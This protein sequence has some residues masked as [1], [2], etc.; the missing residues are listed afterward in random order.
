MV[1]LAAPSAGSVLAPVLDPAFLLLSVLLAGGYGWLLV[2]RARHHPDRPWPVGRTVAFGSGVVVLLAATH[3]GLARYD[4]SLLSL[5][6]LQHLLLGMLAPVLLAL[7][8]PITLALQGLPRGGQVALLRVLNHPVCQVLAHPLVAWSLFSLS[9]FALYFSP[10]FGLS[11]RN[12][13]VH[14]GV[15]LHFVAAGFLFCWSVLAVDQGRRRVGHAVRLL[16]VVMTVPFHAILGLALQ[17]GADSP[18]GADVFTPLDA[19]WGSTLAADQRLAASALWGLGEIWG[20]A[21][22][23]VVAASWMRDDARRQAREDARL[24]AEAAAAPAS[25]EA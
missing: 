11:V 9:L 3:L 24:D 5:H 17:G 2:A 6:M 20:V 18:L 22:V 8:A 7:G 23:V 14:T 16:A 10:L 4:T 13:L 1:A 21:L 25:A 12:D 19:S 15:H